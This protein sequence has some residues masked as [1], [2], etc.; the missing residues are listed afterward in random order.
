LHTE[1][2]RLFKIRFSAREHFSMA[3]AE[4]R[5]IALARAR[6]TALEN[7]IAHCWTLHDA[8]VVNGNEQMQIA[9]LAQ[10]T[11]AQMTIAAATI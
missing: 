1:N 5:R 4:E 9:L 8:A 11:A 6:I 7:E 2:G 10:M 3:T